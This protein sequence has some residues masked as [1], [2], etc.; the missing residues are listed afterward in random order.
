MEK[1][2]KNRTTFG[3]WYF[4][5]DRATRSSIIYQLKEIGVIPSR[6]RN[7]MHSPIIPKPQLFEAIERITGKTI[8]DLFPYQ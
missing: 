6:V 8:S 4:R 3:E 7:W 1:T 2:N 5:Q